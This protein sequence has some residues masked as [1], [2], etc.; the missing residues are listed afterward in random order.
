MKIELMSTGPVGLVSGICSSDFRHDV[1]CVNK[2]PGKLAKLN[3]SAV[4]AYETCLQ[5]WTDATVMADLHN[6]YCP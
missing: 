5:D 6:I 1:F 2:D 3:A 4:P